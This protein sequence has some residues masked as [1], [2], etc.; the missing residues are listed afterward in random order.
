[1]NQFLKGIFST[2]LLIGN[3]NSKEIC[4]EICKLAYKF[5][6]SATDAGLVS[7]KWN[8][9]EKSSNQEDFIKNG[10]TSFNS[11]SLTDDPE[12]ANVAAFIYDFASTMIK[13]VNTSNRIPV[14]DNMWT[15][16]Y[17]NKAFVPEHIHSNSL[18]SGVFYA[19]TPENCGDIVFK[20]LAAVA[21]NMCIAQI[22]DFPAVETIYTQEVK[23][24]VMVI[25]PSWLPHYTLPNESNEDRIMVSF[26]INM[27]KN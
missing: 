1:M 5:R 17:P 24:G 27:T 22:R 12:W 19:K 11:G 13:S 16:I 20:D 26:N 14:I 7:N 4:Q 8:Y 18:L 23:E 15:T 2:P 3:S 25:F 21:K 9:A 6:E 10:V